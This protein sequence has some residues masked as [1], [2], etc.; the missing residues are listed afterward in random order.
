MPRRKGT[1]QIG[2]LTLWR[3]SS[4][5]R[6]LRVFFVFRSKL[7]TQGNRNVSALIP[8]RQSERLLVIHGALNLVTLP[9]SRVHFD[10]NQMEASRYLGTL[11]NSHKL[12][13]PRILAVLG[14]KP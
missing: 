8:V 3:S 9:C 10:E 14:T 13:P 1:R 6:T 5:R 4:A 2:I 12:Q 7:D 11:G